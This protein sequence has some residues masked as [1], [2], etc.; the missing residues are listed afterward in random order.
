MTF[1]NSCDDGLDSADCLITSRLFEGVCTAGIRSFGAERVAGGGGCC[2]A[3]AFVF[4]GPREPLDAMN[5]C[6]GLDGC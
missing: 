2:G 1:S 4:G 6:C 3:F 5:S